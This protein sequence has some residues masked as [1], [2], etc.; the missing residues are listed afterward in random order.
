MVSKVINVL[1]WLEVQVLPLLAKCLQCGLAGGIAAD[2]CCSYGVPSL[3]VSPLV[4]K[5]ELH[6]GQD[7]SNEASHARRS[8]S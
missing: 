4:G 6:L 3:L 1:T 8:W 2:A 7:Y 5:R